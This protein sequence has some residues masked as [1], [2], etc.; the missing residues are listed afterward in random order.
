[1]RDLAALKD[2]LRNFAAARDWEQFHNPKN[3]VMALGIEVAELAEHF[4]WLTPEE[5]AQIPDHT[6]AEVAAEIA[7][8]QMYLVR[9]ADVLAVDILQAV[10]EKSVK[11]EAKY[12]ADQVR[13][14]AKKYTA[15]RQEQHAQGNA[16]DE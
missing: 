14:S 10:R 8:I 5:A 4:Q 16:T 15:Y 13:G 1:M 7:D 9:L 3:L 11:N 2:Y 12:P 6:R